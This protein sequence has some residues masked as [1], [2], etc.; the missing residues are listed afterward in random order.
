MRNEPAI[1]IVR[2]GTG[3]DGT[4]VLRAVKKETTLLRRIE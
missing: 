3:S 1:C 4:L 2:S